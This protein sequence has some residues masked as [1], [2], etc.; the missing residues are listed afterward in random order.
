[1]PQFYSKAIKPETETLPADRSYWPIWAQWLRDR[2]LHGPASVFLEA[3]GPLNI[4][5]AQLAWVGQPLFQPSF[6]GG[7]WQAFAHLLED[8]HEV[9]AFASYLREE[10]SQ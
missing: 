9:E 5:L 4:L 2:G 6:A 1:M 8:H 10:D 7:H 3:A